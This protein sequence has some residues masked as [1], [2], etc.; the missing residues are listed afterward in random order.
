[1][2]ENYHIEIEFLLQEIGV[3]K[4]QLKVALQGLD[5]LT[6]NGD[7]LGIAQKTLDA[8]DKVTK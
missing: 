2:N 4:E 3:L 7:L 1:M 5:A 6:E 8:I